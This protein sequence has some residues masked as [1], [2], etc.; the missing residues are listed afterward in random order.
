MRFFLAFDVGCIECGED[1]G[2]IG[3]FTDR[4][5]AERACA[6][7][8]TKR[9]KDWLGEHEMVVWNIDVPVGDDMG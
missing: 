1:S 2:P 9:Q 3:V 7:A 6:D 4:E 5:A 8:Q